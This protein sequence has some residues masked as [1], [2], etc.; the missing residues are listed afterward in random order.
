MTRRRLV[1]STAALLVA[2]AAGLLA[3]QQADEASRRE[4]VRFY[5]NG[6]DLLSS[7]RFER[8]A[9]EF[10]KAVKKIHSSRSPTTTSDAPT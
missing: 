6:L 2:L 3:Q 7:E 8:A 1:F 4:A 5:Q 9:E 10:T